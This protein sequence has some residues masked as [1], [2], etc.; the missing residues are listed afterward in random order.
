MGV[1]M[2]DKPEKLHDSKEHADMYS[3]DGAPPGVFVPNMSDEDAMRWKAKFVGRKTDTP[4]VELRCNGV[5]VVL[6]F[7]GYKY[8]YYNTRVTQKAHDKWTK[9]GR[10]EDAPTVM[11]IATS[12]PMMFSMAEYEEFQQAIAEGFEALK[13]LE[14]E[15]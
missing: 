11:H 3:A 8:K 13:K 10:P 15:G 12:G 4:Q 1:L 6:G 2:W 14:E 7:R 5:V 9:F